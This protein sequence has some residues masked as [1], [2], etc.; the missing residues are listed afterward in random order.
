MHAMFR[1]YLD[2]RDAGAAILTH[3]YLLLGCALPVRHPRCLLD[4]AEA[5]L[6]NVPPQLWLHVAMFGGTSWH[7]HDATPALAGVLML[8]LGDSAVRSADRAAWRVRARHR[9]VS[10]AS[11]VGT[12]FGAH[13]WPGT[14]KTIEG[15]MGGWTCIVAVSQ[16]AP[17][18]GRAG[19]TESWSARLRL[20]RAPR[21]C[22]KTY[23]RYVYRRQ[24]R[25]VPAP[26]WAVSQVSS[27]FAAA[28]L[29]ACLLES[30]T[31]QI[32]NLFLPLFY[33][34]VLLQCSVFTLPA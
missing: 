31:E 28:T 21:W 10:Q 23:R 25:R 9:R 1:A 3:S 4:P 17:L 18:C 7:G 26:S 29:L 6:G 15:T 12:R 33:Y 22:S 19:L 30:F 32:D 16:H 8:G 27:R 11:L 13:K 34:A 24:V 5:H 20:P 14:R 2:A